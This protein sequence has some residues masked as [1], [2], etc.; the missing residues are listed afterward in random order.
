MTKILVIEDEDHIRLEVMDWLQFEGYE[1]VGAANGRL[2]LEAAEREIPDLIICDVVMPEMDGHRV[3]LEVRSHPF[4]HHIPFIFLTAR[5]S[6]DAMRKGM[7]LGADD[8]ITKPF[9]LKEILGAVTSR[10]EKQSAQNTLFQTQLDSLSDE[11]EHEREKQLLK[12]RLVGMFSHDFRNP[13]A[14]ILAS[15]D[16]L[17]DYDAQLPPDRKQRHFN[18]MRVSVRLLL[19]MLDDMLFVAQMENDRLK[20]EPQRLD[21]S[22]FVATIVEEFAMIYKTTHNLVFESNVQKMVDI[23]PKILRQITANLISNAVKYSP[24]G[25]D[26][27]VRLTQGPNGVE[28]SVQDSGIGIP[29]EALAHLFEPFY[30]VENAKGIKGTG[31]GLSIVKQ[32]VET[33][34]GSIQVESTP[35]EGSRFTVQLPQGSP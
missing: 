18:R 34:G 35:G 16:I 14:A 25:G 9:M 33:W 1:V 21:A 11:I 31:L 17:Q 7:N 29:Q 2:G 8:Y 5:A 23:D 12:A 15:V 13:L 28:L 27:I 32:A 6:R 22:F 24:S 19:Q 30:R 26:V 10:L 4:L 3:L 20:Y